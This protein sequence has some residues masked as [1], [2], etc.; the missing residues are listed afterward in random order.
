VGEDNVLY[1][2]NG[3]ATLLEMSGAEVQE[4]LKRTDVILLPFGA[5]EDHGAHLPLGTDCMEGREI[6]RRTAVR[7]A[8]LDCPVV[9]GPVIPFG[10]SSYHLGF[11]GTISIT[12][13]T[14]VTLVKEICLSLYG[15]GFR[16]FILIHGH[17]GSLSSMMVAAQEIVD[18]T[19]DATAV[20]LNWMVALSKVYHTIQVS[21]KGESHGGEGETSRIMAT[22]PELVH[23]ERGT[24]YHLPPEQLRKIQSPE[25]M[26]TGGGIYYGIRSFRDLTPFGQIGDPTLARVETGEKGYE[27]IVEWLTSVIKRDFFDERRLTPA[28][29]GERPL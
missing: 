29:V 21:K 27:V 18:A 15:G 6:C 11:P 7:L 28:M 16:N 20:V 8:E 13:H 25:H 9:I 19:P 4:A 3:P 24:P 2:Q 1:V 5:I 12:S 23:P 14:L 17:D 10:T 22:H 26:K